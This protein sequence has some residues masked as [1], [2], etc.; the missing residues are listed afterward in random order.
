MRSQRKPN[1]ALD[2]PFKE[3]HYDGYNKICTYLETISGFK[4]VVIIRRETNHGTSRNSHEARK[5]IFEK[6]DRFIFS[7]DD[8][9]FSP[10]FL[11]F[12]NKGLEKFKDDSSVLA[13]CGY[14]HLYNI[15]HNDNNFFRQNVDFSAWG[16][17]VWR[18]R[19]EKYQALLTP[20]YFRHS[21]H[22]PLN[23]IRVWRNGLNRLRQFFIIQSLD[24]MAL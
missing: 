19:Y 21:F 2:Y 17:G 23:V 4:N 18:D 14:R 10:N 11:E 5:I 13:I 7:E 6:Y 3:E 1:I 9:V 8:N 20:Q 16:Y 22:N 12:I 15:K 24:G